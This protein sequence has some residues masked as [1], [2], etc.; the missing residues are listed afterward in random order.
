MFIDCFIS[1]EI[2][3]GLV[4]LLCVEL[5]LYLGIVFDGGLFECWFWIVGLVFIG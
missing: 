1:F 5:V 2:N 3:F 4:V